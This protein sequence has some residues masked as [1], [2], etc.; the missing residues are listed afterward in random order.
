[1]P[2]STA[3]CLEWMC[4]RVLDRHELPAHYAGRG[5]ERI[6]RAAAERRVPDRALEDDALP[7]DRRDVDELLAPAREMPKPE[8]LAGGRGERERIRVGCAVHT[9]AVHR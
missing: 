7:D 5:I 4:P 8:H 1:M 3:A 2:Q 6:D 9:L